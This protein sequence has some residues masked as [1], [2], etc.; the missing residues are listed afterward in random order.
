[1]TGKEWLAANDPEYVSPQ[2]KAAKTRATEFDTEAYD[3]LVEAQSTTVAV[4]INGVYQQRAMVGFTCE[5]DGETHTVEPVECSIVGNP[6]ISL[7]IRDLEEKSNKRG[8]RGGKRRGK[9]FRG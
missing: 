7:I 8:K 5:A 1:M 6:E 3:E 9:K 2:Q 4:K